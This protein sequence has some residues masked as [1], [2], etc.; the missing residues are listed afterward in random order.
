MEGWVV[1]R[2]I[3]QPLLLQGRKFDLRAYCL[4]ARTTPHL[5]FF[6][7][8]YCKVALELYS[9]QDLE[10]K[11]AHLT[12]AC[13]QKQHPDYKAS[14]RGQ[15]IWSEAEAEAE[16]LS[17]GQRT[18]EQGP[19]WPGVHEQMKRVIASTFEASK[20]LLERRR[21]YF[22]LLGLDFLIDEGFQLHLLEVNSNPAMFFDSSPVLQDLVPRLIGSALDI[23]LAAQRPG[24]EG[25]VPAYTSPWELVVD[26][27]AGFRYQGGG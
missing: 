10:N 8:G 27:A 23:V 26:E 17:S 22:D 2:Y 5:W 14:L 21:G 16:L 4:V 24:A 18:V 20:E 11:L 3:E 6:H 13:M 15:H 1:Q 12:N 25:R 7:P 19:L 9:P